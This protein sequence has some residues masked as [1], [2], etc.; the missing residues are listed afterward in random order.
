MERS[1]ELFIVFVQ[2]LVV[3]LV[4]VL[5]ILNAPVW[6]TYIVMHEVLGITY[7]LPE[8]DLTAAQKMGFY[9]IASIFW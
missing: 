4:D 7:I 3:F 5:W 2:L 8:G 9:L 1:K 6:L